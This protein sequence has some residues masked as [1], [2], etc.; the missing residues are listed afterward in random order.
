ME[1]ISKSFMDDQPSATTHFTSGTFPLPILCSLGGILSGRGRSLRT[2]CEIGRRVQGL[3]SSI[4]S[5]VNLPLASRSFCPARSGLRPAAQCYRG[6]IWLSFLVGS[7]LA[8]SHTDRWTRTVGDRLNQT[9][10]APRR[11]SSTLSGTRSRSRNDSKHP[12][13]W[14]GEWMTRLCRCVQCEY[15]HERENFSETRIPSFV[16]GSPNGDEPMFL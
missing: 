4:S 12:G 1:V 2:G 14:C 3:S 11:P 10:S 9:W 5:L 15:S 6:E 7:P 16:A 8:Q 13:L